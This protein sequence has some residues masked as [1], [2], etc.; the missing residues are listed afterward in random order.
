MLARLNQLILLNYSLFGIPW[1]LIATILASRTMQGMLTKDPQFWALLI[2]AFTAARAVGMALNRLIDVEIDAKNPRT[3]RRPLPLKLVTRK[4]VKAVIILGSFVFVFSCYFLNM[5]CF[6][7]SPIVLFQLFAYSYTKRFTSFC[8]FFLGSIHFFAPIFA[9]I[10][11]TGSLSIEPLLLGFALWLL[12]AGNDMIYAL[13]D[14]SFDA[15]EGLKSIPVSLGVEG[16]WW[17]VRLVHLCA[18]ALLIALG[19]VAKLESLYYLGV[20][21]LFLLYSYFH[22]NRVNP[23]KMF[24]VCNTWG[25]LILLIFTLGSLL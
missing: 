17:I 8:H 15:R 14:L 13:Q 16:T 3:Y 22:L 4:E 7:L 23:E 18:F 25:G 11:I 21:I 1:I 20:G 19:V 5:L 12:I 24:V 2:L 9:W 6:Y 10:A